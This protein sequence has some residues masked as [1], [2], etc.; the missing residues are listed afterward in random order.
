ML[1]FSTLATRP[2]GAVVFEARSDQS[3]RGKLGGFRSSTRR[4][5]LE[6]I[7]PDTSA[8][9]HVGRQPV[10][11]LLEILSDRSQNKGRDRLASSCSWRKVTRSAE[12]GAGLERAGRTERGA[13][14]HGAHPGP[15]GGPSWL[16]RRPPVRSSIR[17]RGRA[18]GAE[19]D[20]GPHENCAGPLCERLLFSWS[21]SACVI[22]P[23]SS[24]SFAC[25]ICAAVELPAA[26][27]LT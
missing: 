14:E 3:G 21:N 18:L 8:G 27:D 6:L 9:G 5:Q 20:S 23:L 7:P 2:P 19:R 25:A 10:R 26:T 11:W 24:N 22:V 13:P 17:R 16:A 12:H 4:S 1:S 15:S